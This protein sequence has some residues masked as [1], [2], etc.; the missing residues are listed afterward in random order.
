M[1]VTFKTGEKLGGGWSVLGRN[2]LSQFIVRNEELGLSIVFESD[3]G[4]GLNYSKVVSCYDMGTDRRYR[5]MR[6]LY[7]YVGLVQ[8][9]SNILYQKFLQ[10]NV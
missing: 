10:S 3:A 4:E 8:G 2:G 5:A 9:F 7:K 6:Y 1:N